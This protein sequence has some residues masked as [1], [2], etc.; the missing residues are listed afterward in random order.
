VSGEQKYGVRLKTNNGRNVD[1]DIYQE[2]L[3]AMN[4]SMQAFLQTG[5]RDYLDIFTQEVALA[6][7]VKA[8]LTAR[9]IIASSITPV[10]LVA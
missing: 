6:V 3:D 9:D 2:I 8:I 1:L 4:Y 7:R 10:N 5:I